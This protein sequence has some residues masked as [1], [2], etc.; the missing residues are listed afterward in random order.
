[1]LRDDNSVVNE[2]DACGIE[3]VDVGTTGCELEVDVCETLL[4]GT[5]G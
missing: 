4:S 1:M 2:D 5:A 3:L